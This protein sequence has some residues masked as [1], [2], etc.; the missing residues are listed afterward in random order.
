MSPRNQAQHFSGK[1]ISEVKVRCQ[2][3][4]KATVTLTQQEDGTVPRAGDSRGWGR[5]EMGGMRWGVGRG[6]G[7]DCRLG[8]ADSRRPPTLPGSLYGGTLLRDAQRN[9][10]FRGEEGGPSLNRDSAPAT[11]LP[12]G[13]QP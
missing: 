11:H 4:P 7:E 10:V 12:G 3:I 9:W 2:K 1:W 5:G 8:R 13:P 6:I